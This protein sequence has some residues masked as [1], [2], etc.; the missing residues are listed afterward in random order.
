MEILGAEQIQALQYYLNLVQYG[1]LRNY[2]C[3]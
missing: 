2:N 3:L 1:N